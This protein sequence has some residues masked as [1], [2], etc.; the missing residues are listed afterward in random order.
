MTGSVSQ[1]QL[2]QQEEELRLREALQAVA[3]GEAPVAVSSKKTSFS[4]ESKSLE[5]GPEE[6]R[7]RPKFD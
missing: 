2:K 1:I 5:F 6:R 3:D 7:R 4:K